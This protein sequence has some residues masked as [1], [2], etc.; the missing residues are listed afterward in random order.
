MPQLDAEYKYVSS[1]FIKREKLDEPVWVSEAYA[2][3]LVQL[4]DGLL[5]F[6]GL[7]VRMVDSE[8]WR[9]NIYVEPADIVILCR[10][11]LGPMSE[12]VEAYPSVCLLLDASLYANSRGRILREC[13]ALGLQP[14]DI[15]SAGA[16]K[17]VSHGDSFS[18]VPMRGK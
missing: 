2:D 5:S 12:L 7:K 17:V 4:H 16:M 10:G 8:H 14:V 6:D 9:D 18:L 13:A 15:S 11:F 3:S 1:P